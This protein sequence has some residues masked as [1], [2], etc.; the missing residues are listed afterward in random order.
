MG[1]TTHT[2]G[3]PLSRLKSKY[4]DADI[5]CPDCGFHDEDGQWTAKTSGDR[6]FYRRICPG[7]G[8]IRKRELR[9]GDEETT[10]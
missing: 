3:N 10:N 6:I 1:P 2:G 8:A 5:E 9:L 4:D 7:C